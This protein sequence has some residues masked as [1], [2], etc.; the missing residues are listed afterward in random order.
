MYEIFDELDSPPEFEYPMLPKPSLGV[1]TQH[2][3]SMGSYSSNTSDNAKV[4]DGY[5]R[6]PPTPPT[7]QRWVMILLLQHL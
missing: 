7:M 6:T 1:A 2:S 3:S 5:D 4:G